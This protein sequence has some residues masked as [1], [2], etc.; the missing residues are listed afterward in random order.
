M[1]V[2]KVIEP[3]SIREPPYIDGRLFL[4]KFHVDPRNI[5]AE[6]AAYFLIG[7]GRVLGRDQ[8][9]IV[10]GSFLVGVSG[11]GV[12]LSHLSLAGAMILTKVGAGGSFSS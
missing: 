1:I 8:G 4:V 12:A 6:R 3:V 9:H 2:G 7:V 11:C 5:E 10:I